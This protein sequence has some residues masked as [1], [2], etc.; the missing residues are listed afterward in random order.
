MAVLAKF[1]NELGM[2]RNRTT[3]KQTSALLQIHPLA[4]L[5]SL[6]AILIVIYYITPTFENWAIVII[7]GTLGSLLTK[8]NR[9]RA[10]M[11]TLTI[12]LFFPLIV[13]IPTFV[14]PIN[15]EFSIISIFSFNINSIPTQWI[16]A[17]EYI[18]R[19][20]A[21]ISIL[22]FISG[23]F[24][25]DQLIFALD[26]LGVPDIFLKIMTLMYRYFGLFGE[27]LTEILRA[28]CCRRFTK[29]KG[30]EYLKHLGN[31]L[32][33]MVIRTL[34][35]GEKIYNSMIVRGYSGV[36]PPSTTSTSVNRTILYT[37]TTI[38]VIVMLVGQI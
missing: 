2:A 36:I 13:S 33:L 11:L 28:D 29:L 8:G 26:K 4:K 6:I 37:L 17:I 38:F 15:E 19:T 3:T 25:V 21:G 10:I 1:E 27:S 23:F 16:P 12:G 34:K 14:L 31:I 30:R 24:P 22:A 9:K 18:M 20:C 35:K 7:G 32:G 5:F